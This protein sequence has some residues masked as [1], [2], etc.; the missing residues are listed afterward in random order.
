MGGQRD[1]CKGSTIAKT[2]IRQAHHKRTNVDA[3]DVETTAVTIRNTA[4]NAA[5][6]GDDAAIDNT[7]IAARDTI[8]EV[9]NSADDPNNNVVD[10]FVDDK[11]VVI[12][13]DAAEPTDMVGGNG[14]P[15]FVDTKQERHQKN[16][17]RSRDQRARH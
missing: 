16:I 11:L 9:A 4:N 17:V 10:A 12:N 13:V 6:D 8:A 7:V 2:V 14:I 15:I 3:T 1:K 5:V